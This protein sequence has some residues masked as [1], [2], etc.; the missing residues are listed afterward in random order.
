MR[1]DKTGVYQI[2]RS[3]IK[4]FWNVESVI[5]IVAV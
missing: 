5:E 3:V 1:T 2:V 4:D